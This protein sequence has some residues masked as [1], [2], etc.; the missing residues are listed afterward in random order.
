[1][2]ETPGLH[3]ARG[4]IEG[5]ADEYG[6]SDELDLSGLNLTELPQELFALTGLVSLDLS[7]NYI[8]EDSRALAA[9][10][11]LTSLDLS[12]NG[13]RADRAWALTALP[14]SPL[15]ICQTILSTLTA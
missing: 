7:E 13:I 11:G 1:M 12:M 9:L 6:V 10:T 3:E 8:S 5:A 15:L 14:G 4:R 2:E